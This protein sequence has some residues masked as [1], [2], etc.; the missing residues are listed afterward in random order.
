M[1]IVLYLQENIKKVQ[2]F[3]AKQFGCKLIQSGFDFDLSKIGNA[4]STIRTQFPSL[5]LKLCC[6]DNGKSGAYSAVSSIEVSKSASGELEVHPFSLYDWALFQSTYC[7]AQN[8][9]NL[10]LIDYLFARYCKKTIKYKALLTTHR[11]RKRNR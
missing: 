6:S 7:I 2:L 11:I 9:M 1:Y 5:H 3:F 10:D 4:K 8:P